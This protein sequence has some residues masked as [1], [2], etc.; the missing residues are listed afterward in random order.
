MESISSVSN[1]AVLEKIIE[2]YA[3]KRFNSRKRISLDKILRIVRAYWEFDKT[4]QDIAREVGCSLCTVFKYWRATYYDRIR[5]KRGEAYKIN[6]E[7][8]E[9]IKNL[10]E[11]G[12]TQTEISRE[13]GVSRQAVGD[14]LKRHSEFPTPVGNRRERYILVKKLI[15]DGL[16]QT[17]IA[18]ELG[19]KCGSLYSY[20]RE[21]PELREMYRTRFVSRH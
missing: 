12:F 6:F 21:N 19:I 8:D 10:I 3:R 11:E 1:R 20:C 9:K 5:R 15:G 4:S 13:L 16:N 17:Q 18:E 14:Y 7:R 2:D